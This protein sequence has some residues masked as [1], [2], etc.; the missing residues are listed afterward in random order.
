MDIDVNESV[1][2]SQN[3]VEEASPPLRVKG[4][5]YQHEGTQWWVRDGEGNGCSRNLIPKINNYMEGNQN[6]PSCSRNYNMIPDILLKK[7]TENILPVGF[8]KKGKPMCSTGVN[9]RNF[10]GKN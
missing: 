4:F 3:N 2:N 8:L 6:N 7:N 1:I 9:G 5:P 10:H